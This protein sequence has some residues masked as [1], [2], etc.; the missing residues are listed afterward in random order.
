MS[1]WYDTEMKKRGIIQP[2]DVE[3][4]KALTNFKANLQRRK[5]A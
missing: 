2:N 1:F 3:S 4:L 5:M